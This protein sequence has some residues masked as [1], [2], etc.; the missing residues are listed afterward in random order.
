M[1]YIRCE[2]IAGRTIIQEQYQAPRWNV[3]VPDRLPPSDVMSEAQ[4]MANARRECRELTIKLN[5]NFSPGDFHLVLDYTRDNRPETIEDAKEDRSAFMRRLRYVYKKAGVILKYAI[6]TEYGKKGGLHHHI[7]VNRDRNIDSDEIRR[8]WKK[9]RIHLN[10]MEDNPNYQ[11]L[12]EYILKTRKYWRKLGGHGRQW[13]CSRNL[14]RPETKKT[15]MKRDAY[16]ELPK[17]KKG[18]VL[19]TQSVR[20][21]VTEDGYPWKSCVYIRAGNDP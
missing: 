20:E 10:P 11:R 5:A 19:D 18:Y 16:F 21:G 2:T 8:I 4:E 7:I 13:T 15:I 17:P 6:V 12:A 14:V 9:G 1:P 3:K